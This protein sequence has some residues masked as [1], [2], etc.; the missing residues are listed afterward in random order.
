MGSSRTAPVSTADGVSTETHLTG[1]PSDGSGYV[2]GMRSFDGNKLR[3][4]LPLAVIC[5]AQFVVVLDVTIVT[6]ALPVVRSYFGS[7]A[8]SLQWVITAYT[9][10]FG[11]LLI[12]GGRIADLIRPRRTFLLGL[13]VFTTASRGMC[14]RLVSG[15][16]RRRSGRAGRRLGVAFTRC[17]GLAQPRQ[18]ARCRSAPRGGLV[19]SSRCD[20]RRE[21]VAARWGA[22]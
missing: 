13:A 16:P 17:A 7:S 14:P 6:T 20:G 5:V 1:H 15:G 18:P 21:R 3:R 4:S 10:A 11:G 12:T 19:D 9:L 8:G 2:S 22:D